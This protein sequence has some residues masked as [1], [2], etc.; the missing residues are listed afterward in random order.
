M[1]SLWLIVSQCIRDGLGEV[2][3]VGGGRKRFGTS[4]IENALQSALVVKNNS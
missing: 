4:T 2:G 3:G 1:N